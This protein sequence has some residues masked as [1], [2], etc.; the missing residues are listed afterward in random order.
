M[1]KKIVYIAPH[2]STGGMPQYLYK[3]MELL[4]NEFDIYCIE[5]SDVTGGVLV[6]QR[7][8]VKSLLG[9]RLL[10]LGENKEELF[11]MLKRINTDVIHLQEIPELFIPNDIAE[12]LY[13]KDRKY[14]IIETSHD[15]SQSAKSKRF[16]PDKFLFVS[17][18]QVGLYKE[19]GI[20]S[21][22]VEYPI[23]FF[24]RTKTKEQAQKDL[25]MNPNIKHVIN[26]GLFTPRKNQAEI[27]EYARLL[28]DHPIQFHFIGNQADNFK[29]YWEPL[30]KDFP[31]NCKWWNERTDVENFYQAADLFLF[32]SRGSQ[33][34]KETMPLVIREAIS[35]QVPSLIYNLNVYE[36]YF[37]KFDNISY[38]D[39]TYGKNNLPKILD[40]VGLKKSKI[41]YTMNG[42]EDLHSYEY[43]NSTVDSIQKYGDSGGQYHATYILKEL[44]PNDFKI[45]KDS[46]FVDL[47]ANIGMSSIYAKEAG[48]KEIIC[49]E[50]DPNLISIIQKNVPE[51]KV[52]NYAIGDKKDNIELYHWP[53]N[54]VN[55]GPKY[56]INVISLKDVLD[57]VGKEIDY[58]KIDI[59]GFEEFIFDDLTQTECSKIKKM[60]L[61]HHNTD[62]TEKFVSKLRDKGFDSFVHNGSGQNYIYAKY[63]KNTTMV[64]HY[65][66]NTKWDV[67]EQILHYSC[68]TDINYPIV[69]SLK[70]YQSD[71]ILWSVKHDTLP[72]NI[73]FWMTPIS[74]NY[75]FLKEQK[76]FTGVKVCIYRDDTGEQIYEMPYF[77]KFVNIPNV[78]LTNFV[79]NHMNY[80]EFFV[81]K[82][83]SKWLDKPYQNVVDVGANVGVFTE[84]ML[85]NSFAKQVYAVECDSI[86][87]K[88]L[89]NNFSRIR[90]VEIIDK[91][92]SSSKGKIK[93]YQSKESPV[94]SSTL[95]PDKLENHNAGMKG[96]NIYEVETITLQE[97]L[98]KC[99][100]I[101]LLK[102]DIEGGE[103]DVIEKLDDNLFG[104]INNIFVECHFFE[105]NY[106]ERY[107]NLKNKLINN[108]YEIEELID[109]SNMSKYAA[110]SECIFAKKL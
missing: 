52:Y 82:K 24:R 51:A 8:K 10:T 54:H 28:K 65:N 26:V 87:L 109:S 73:Q 92:L 25:G 21:D 47:G 55:Q 23:E 22:V 71:T 107:Q 4:V 35:W 96:D 76:Y 46:V 36:N 19:L 2:L 57:I 39:F 72:A 32:T 34:D 59:E 44:E 98:E 95:S 78:K 88:D 67:E 77:Y 62:N 80:V 103:Y 63:R 45:E 40:K 56:N 15:S 9:N 14:C 86:A 18:Y 81:D 84:Y 90:N 101:D 42:E 38:L 5:W 99:V 91:A 29:Y 37:D 13:T 75:L 85:Q 6:V 64:Q 12:K 106:A 3:Q 50:P 68:N 94:I 66:I 83:Y 108:G 7:N 93:F 70:H 100:T 89:R 43:P 60:F 58:L 97:I 53:Y 27:I 20:P 30:M 69:L 110:M 104:S 41:F 11:Q 16:F 17:E 105:K 48:A 33:H 79:A 49:F 1:K 61:E 74:K 31:S 102:I